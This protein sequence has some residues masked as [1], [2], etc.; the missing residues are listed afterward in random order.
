MPMTADYKLLVKQGV[1]HMVVGKP[2]GV[3]LAA[4]LVALVCDA[5]HD[6]IENVVVWPTLRDTGRS[7][8]PSPS[9]RLRRNIETSIG[10]MVYTNVAMREN[11]DHHPASA[12]GRVPIT[13]W[14]GSSAS[15][16]SRH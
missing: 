8:L 11:F 10:A 14:I 7:R 2:A 16:C 6:C 12:T 4:V 1:I 15:F 3:D 9:P 5:I 13:S